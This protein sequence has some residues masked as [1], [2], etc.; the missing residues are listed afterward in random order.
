MTRTMKMAKM[1]KNYHK[2]MLHTRQKYN[3]NTWKYNCI[4]TIFLQ[5]FYGISLFPNF[6]NFVNYVNFVN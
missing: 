6:V 4:A 2:L 5:Y 3:R 1:N